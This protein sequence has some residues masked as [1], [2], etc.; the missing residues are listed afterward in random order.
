MTATASRPKG[1]GDYDPDEF[2]MTLGEHLEELRHRVIRGLIGFVVALAICIP[3]AKQLLSIICQPLV[4]ALAY[5]DL[6]PQLFTD[7]TTEVFM[8]WVQVCVIAAVAIAGPWIV[9]Q[10][11]QFVATGLYPG[12]R[13]AV[14]RYVPLA[15]TLFLSGVVF[16]YFVVLPLT[17]RFFV[18]FAMSIPLDMP[19]GAPTHLAPP[20]TQASFVQPLNADPAHPQPYQIWFNTRERRLKVDTGDAVRNIPFSGDR[21][22]AAHFELADYLSLVF[23]LLLTFGICFQL[24]LVVLLLERL[25]IVE[26]EQLKAM[27]RYV[28]FGMIVLAAVVSPGDVITATL[29]LLFPLILLY[30]LGIL[31]VRINARRPRQPLN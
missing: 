21:L 24:P 15:I 9:F 12:E 23:R 27:R 6:N 26:V 20:S 10:I 8:A 30:E 25:G 7:Q 2:R 1:R 3:M 5:F 11:W 18:A 4:S 19:L 16:V 28:Y 31:L 29:A 17:M 22:F 13:K 14:T